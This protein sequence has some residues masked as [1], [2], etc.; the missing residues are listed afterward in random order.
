M[1]THPVDAGASITSPRISR[2]SIRVTPR[3]SSPARSGGWRQASPS[4][5]PRAGSDGHALVTVLTVVRNGAATLEACVRSVTAQTWP[6]VEHVIVDGA[7]TDGTIALLERLGA[8]VA[9][10][11]SEPDAG[12]YDAL[13]KGLR[14]AAGQAYVVLG[15]DDVLLPTAIEALMRHA[16]DAEVVC[17]RVRFESPRQGS[18]LIRNHSAGT[19]IKQDAHRRLG[20][21]DASYRIAADTKFLMSARR[22]GIVRDIDDVVGIFTVGGASGNYR[23]NVLEHARAMRESGAWSTVHALLWRTPRLALAAWRGRTRR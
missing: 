13:N 20:P 19:L 22:A 14:L 4:R 7:S 18:L 8:E 12:I 10:W 16:D 9:Y 3:S 2:P 21:Y 6:N 5:E 17:G 23:A 1:P 11:I 15:C